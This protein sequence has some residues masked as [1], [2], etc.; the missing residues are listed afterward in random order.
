MIY[1]TGD[2]HGTI[3]FGKIVEWNLMNFMKLRKS[4]YL[5]ICGDFGFIW[6][7]EETDKEREQLEWLNSALPCKVLFVDGNHENFDRLEKFPEYEWKGGKIRRIRKN[8]YQL[9]RGQVFTI[10]GKTI[11]TMGGA[12]SPDKNYRIT[13]ED[14]YFKYHPGEKPYHFLWWSQELFTD[15]D[16][17]EAEKNIEKHG[18]KVDYVI[19][20]CAP[21][22]VEEGN[23]HFQENG[24]GA[25]SNRC[26]RYLDLVNGVLDY[27]KWYCGHY[28]VDKWLA[29]KI[30]CIYKDVVPLYGA[31][32]ETNV[33]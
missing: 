31:E 28:H 19:T 2:T 16:I 18:R 22:L 13:K 14:G 23:F 15:E 21:F 6:D 26:Q 11:F 30:R 27:K 29:K 20:H 8:I 32:E 33:K 4:D 17:A 12:P 9:M 10:E 3:D 24:Y 7:K 25:Y 1:V 5:I